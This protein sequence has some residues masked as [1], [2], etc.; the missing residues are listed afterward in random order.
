MA[1][2]D[3]SIYPYAGNY[4]KQYGDERV[5]VLADNSSKTKYCVEPVSQS[6]LDEKPVDVIYELETPEI[7]GRYWITTASDDYTRDPMD[8]TVAGSN[9]MDTWTTLHT[10]TNPGNTLNADRMEVLKFN[11]E[12][13]TAYKYYR[14]QITR[15]ETNFSAIQFAGWNLLYKAEGTEVPVEPTIDYVIDDF[16]SYDG[17]LGR[18]RFTPNCLSVIVLM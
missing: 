8:W 11:V 9:D 17:D 6:A 1:N 4:C 13:E 2:V 3:K 15:G 12:N 7:L 10:V 5:E 16:E 14:L 18:F